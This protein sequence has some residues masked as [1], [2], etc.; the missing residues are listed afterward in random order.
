MTNG[1]SRGASKLLQ[2]EGAGP[3][4]AENVLVKTGRYLQLL[5]DHKRKSRDS[6]QAKSDVLA[7]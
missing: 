3:V 4:G 7:I 6:R 5:W 2:W 1:Q